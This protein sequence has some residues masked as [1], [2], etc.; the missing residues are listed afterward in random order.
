[1]YHYV[2]SFQAVPTPEYNSFVPFTW[3]PTDS[4]VLLLHLLCPRG[5]DFVLVP[6]F[7]KFGYALDNKQY[8]ICR[9]R[10]TVDCQTGL[11][12]C[13]LAQGSIHGRHNLHC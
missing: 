11:I 8:S 6:L 9:S 5:A 4:F 3:Y 1:M 10:V 7:S 12:T 2:Q 13:K